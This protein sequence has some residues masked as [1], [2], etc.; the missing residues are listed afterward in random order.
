[1]LCG[2][3]YAAAAAVAL[4]AGWA[5]R[6]LHPLVVVLVADLAAT[7][8][9]FGFS[10]AADNSSIY[11]PYWSVLP[12]LVALY[13]WLQPGAASGSTV[14]PLIV[15]GLVLAWAAR[16]TFNWARRWEGLGSE[17]W[18]YR[19]FRTQWG[20]GYWV[21]SFFGIHLV[22]TLIVYLACL[23]FWP[24]SAAGSQPVG[25]L[26][27]AAA[28]V[29][30]GAILIETAADEQLQ[31]FLTGPREPGQLLDT[32]LWAYSRHPN[33]FG[34][35]AFWWG[36]WLFGLAAAPAFWWTVVGPLVMTALF[37]LIS[38]PMIDRRSLVRRPAFA[39]YSRRVSS[40][41]PWLPKP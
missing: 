28:V 27:L 18:R 4:A 13:W 17:D 1:M 10:L 5:A 23:P 32:G 40:L 25:L 39:D 41:V 22:P 3:A 12:P 31:R 2:A 11:D 37:V 29:T 16:L 19:D 30:T 34:E 14:R 7:G 8:V 21:G 20:R 9:V 15:S 24:V 6:D 38:I 26:D 36:I 33:Y 35:V